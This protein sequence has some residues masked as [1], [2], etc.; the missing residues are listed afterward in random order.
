MSWRI[1]HANPLAL[2]RELPSCWAQTCLLAPPRDTPT[3]FLLAVLGEVHRVL[4]E[5]GTLWV[6]LPG[7][8][9]TPQLLGS[10]QQEEWRAQQYHKYLPVGLRAVRWQGRLLFFSKQP[11]F[12]FHPHRVPPAVHRH[13][14]ARCVRLGAPGLFGR[15]GGSRR[16]WC[17]PDRRM[18]P[19]ELVQWCI[20]AS[21]TP[22]ACG[23]C[24]TPCQQRPRG[25]HTRERW[26]AACPHSNSR[27]RCLVLDPFCS[28]G[29]AGVLAHRLGRNY[30]GVTD[31]T[32]VARAYQ[33][34]NIS[35]RPGVGR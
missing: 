9:V 27:G 2:L 5:D 4:R 20:L 17:V 16:A 21:T 6:T 32:K 8:G 13:N 19:C 15:A 1:E 34:A 35:T 29:T 11:R 3:P 26:R 31:D 22:R 12:L 18:L 14:A 23:V 28:T 25:T 24:G 30:L 33:Q 10:I 7:R